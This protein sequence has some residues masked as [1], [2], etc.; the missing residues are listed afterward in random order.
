MIDRLLISPLKL[1]DFFGVVGIV[2]LLAWRAAMFFMM[3][4]LG[5]AASA[6]FLG[7]AVGKKRPHLYLTVFAIGTVG[8]LLAKS[9]SK[10]VSRFEYDPKEGY[11]EIHKKQLEMAKEEEAEAEER[12]AKI[13]FAED[14]PLDKYD[15]A[16][17]RSYDKKNIYEAAAAGVEVEPPEG[18][19]GKEKPPGDGDEG[20]PTGEEEEPAEDGNGVPAYRNSTIIRSWA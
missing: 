3:R 1:F 2:S 6:R 4:E 11:A 13:E 7:R 19:E 20:L 18:P 10:R 14:D 17:V 9:N 15:L 12:A 8:L 5:R 16:G